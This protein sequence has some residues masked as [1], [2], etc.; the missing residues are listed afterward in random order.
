MK[1]LRKVQEEEF[2]EEDAPRL[3][4]ETVVVVTKVGEPDSR[5]RVSL[6]VTK[7]SFRGVKIEVLADT[8]VRRTILNLGDWEKGTL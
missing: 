8:G 5:T 1:E 4:E 3:K 7:H 2:S 6:G